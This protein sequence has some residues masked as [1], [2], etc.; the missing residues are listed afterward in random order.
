MI[1]SLSQILSSL[2]KEKLISCRYLRCQ[3]LV[4]TLFAM[5]DLL[6]WTPSA[7]LFYSFI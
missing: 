2:D 1:T 3:I 4:Y 7:F 6:S 5:E